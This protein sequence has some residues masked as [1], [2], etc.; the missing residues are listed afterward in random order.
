M[1]AT[2]SDRPRGH[3]YVSRSQ[4]YQP[5]I[6]RACD[7]RTPSNECECAG[8]CSFV[9]L[10]IEDRRDQILRHLLKVRWLHRVTRPAFRKRTDRRGVTEKLCQRNFSVNDGQVSARLDAVHLAATPV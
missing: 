9:L 10:L 6:D 8:R 5:R 2:E 3:R 1:S 7:D 4:Q